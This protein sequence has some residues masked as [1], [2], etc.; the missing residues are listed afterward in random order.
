MDIL[1]YE[2]D[3]KSHGFLLLLIRT[4]SFLCVICILVFDYILISFIEI[5]H[6]LIV[7]FIY[8]FFSLSMKKN[9]A[10]YDSCFFFVSYILYLM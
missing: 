8:K 2:Q 1:K 9:Q 10:Q 6:T 7:F 4:L 3:K 5:N